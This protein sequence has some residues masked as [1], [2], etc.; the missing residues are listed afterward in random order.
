PS[1]TRGSA[2]PRTG[3]PPPPRPTPSPVRPPG[4]AYAQVVNVATGRC[5]EVAG[6]FENG[7]DVVTVPCSG[8]ASQR[9]RVDADRGVLQS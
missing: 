2:P 4:A 6:D 1:P 9:W 5:L 7:T 3:T 8:S